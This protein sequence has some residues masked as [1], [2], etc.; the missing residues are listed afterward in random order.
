MFIGIKH[1]LIFSRLITTT[2]TTTTP[3]VIVTSL[4]SSNHHL[5]KHKQFSMLVMKVITC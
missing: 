1:L 5:D 3:H 4:D 2:I